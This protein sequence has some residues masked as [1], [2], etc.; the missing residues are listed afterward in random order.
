MKQGNDRRNTGAGKRFFISVGHDQKVNVGLRLLR[1]GRPQMEG[2]REGR[3]RTRTPPGRDDQSQDVPSHP[4]SRPGPTTIFLLASRQ[5]SGQEASRGFHSSGDVPCGTMEGNGTLMLSL[6]GFIDVNTY[7]WVYF[8]F[9][10]A[11]YILILCSNGT[12]I[13][14]VWI[15]RNL[16][17][18]MYV[19]IACLS[20]NSLFLSTAIYPKLFA[21]VLSNHQSISLSFC[22]VQFYFFYSL[23]ASDIT[24][25]LVMSYDRYVSICRPLRYASVMG[26]RRVSLFLA[27]AWFLPACVMMVTISMQSK[28][29]ICSLTS[30]GFFCNATVLKIYCTIPLP[31][32]GW[33]FF[34]VSTVALIP[35][36]LILFTYVK[37]F[38]VS[39]YHSLAWKKAVDTCLPHVIVLIATVGLVMCDGV[40]GLLGSALPKSVQL[41]MT[42]QT[43]VYAPLLNPIVYGLKLKKIRKHVE[44]L[45]RSN[46][47]GLMAN[48]LE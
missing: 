12:I 37:I 31:T 4:P 26:T 5:T 17:E 23:G 16:H 3:S 19:F 22:L 28:Q 46:H 20:L 32:M 44:K 9:L 35:V 29:K 39:S 7:R 38:I 10:L 36:S 41:I 30:G 15:Y 6:D 48:G 13:C 1:N 33:T 34:A 18:P 21:D 43:V 14:L 8:L 40:V 47:V 11:M 45:F 2:G 42:V 27:L 25:L 24:L